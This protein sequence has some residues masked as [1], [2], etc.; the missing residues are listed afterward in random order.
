[1]KMILSLATLLTLAL[2]GPVSAGAA[3]PP[4]PMPPLDGCWTLTESADL[5]LPAAAIERTYEIDFTAQDTRS[6]GIYRGFG[7]TGRP[8]SCREHQ[9]LMF[10]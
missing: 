1:M 7:G 10:R 5:K 9:F 2:T 6:V 4:S 3:A 8:K